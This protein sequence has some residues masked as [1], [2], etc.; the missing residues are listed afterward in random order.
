MCWNEGKIRFRDVDNV[1]KV[2]DEFDFKRVDAGFFSLFGFVIE[3]PLL[4][5]VCKLAVFIEFLVV[6]ALEKSGVIQ[7][8][9]GVFDECF[10]NGIGEV[11]EIRKLGG[12]A[13]EIGRFT[14][15]TLFDD[16]RQDF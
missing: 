13:F 10:F 8:G 14:F 3:Q 12:G 2:I 15:G 16:F 7:V 9:W 4:S 6:S 5:V 11:F 1:V